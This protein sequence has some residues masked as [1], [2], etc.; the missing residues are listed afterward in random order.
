MGE[1]AWSQELPADSLT[2]SLSRQV[3]LNED[4]A[5]TLGSKL[6]ADWSHKLGENSQFGLSWG[7]SSVVSAGDA[8]V[9]GT[10]RQSLTASYGH[11]LTPDWA[12]NA[13]VTLTEIDRDSTGAASDTAE[14]STSLP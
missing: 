12:L 1:L 7:L 10:V 11:A 2:L 8:V 6:S 5:D 9:D 14:E 13:G 4:E 3:A